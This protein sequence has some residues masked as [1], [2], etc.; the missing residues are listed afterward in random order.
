M[1]WART[2]HSRPFLEQWQRVRRWHSRLHNLVGAPTT[3]PDD[4]VDHALAVLQNCF[5]M[6]DWLLV[7]FPTDPPVQILFASTPELRLC[8]DIVNGSKHLQIKP[9]RA[10]VDPAH[11]VH[12]EYKPASLD[13]T[14]PVGYEFIVAWGGDGGTMRLLDLADR[15]VEEVGRFLELH[16][17][18]HER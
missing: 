10:S 8:R 12:R 11:R 18:V 14:R 9:T 13:G 3:A 5:A 17:L 16:G 1:S 7:D 4:L 15:C 6:R 2:E